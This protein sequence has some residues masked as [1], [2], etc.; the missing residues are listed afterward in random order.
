MKLY[1][2]LKLT[3]KDFDTYDK[4][5]N[6]IVTVCY[7]KENGKNDSYDTFCIELMK[8][9]DVVQAI[10]DYELVVDWSKL[11][12]DNMEKFRQFARVYWVCQYKD[13]EDEFIYQWIKEFHLYLA[14]YVSE[15][16]YDTL[17]EFVKTLEA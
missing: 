2:V 9:V 8:R 6:G 14:G 5:Y 7:V 4:V 1:D 17:V 16:F 3:E 11:I 12:V 13:D 15:D 10:S